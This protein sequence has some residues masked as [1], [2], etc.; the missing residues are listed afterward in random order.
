MYKAFYLDRRKVC[1]WKKEIEKN[2]TILPKSKYRVKFQ[3][4]DL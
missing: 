1:E 4:A 3:N 2:V